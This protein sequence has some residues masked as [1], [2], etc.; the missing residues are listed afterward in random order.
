L[1]KLLQFNPNKRITIEEALAHP[2]VEAFHSKEKENVCEKIIK[3]PMDDNTKY[4]VKE[5]RQRLYDDILKRKRDI[6]KIILA[7]QRK[8]N[9]TS[10]IE[11]TSKSI[12][13]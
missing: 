11:K 13:K 6:K 1:S 10:A 8:S 3:I 2:Y 9:P 7:Q 4:T 12:I 5:Y